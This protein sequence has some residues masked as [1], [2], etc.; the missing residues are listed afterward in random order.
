MAYGHPTSAL[1]SDESVQVRL[2]ALEYLAN[3][4][5]DPGLIRRTIE[6]AGKQSNPAILLQAASYEK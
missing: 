3:Q 4:G 6:E 1:R 5:V 2:L